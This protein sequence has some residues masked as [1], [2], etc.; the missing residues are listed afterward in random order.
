MPKHK[1]TKGVASKVRK[2][3]R[4]PGGKENRQR[5]RRATGGKR[6]AARTGA[7]VAVVVAVVAVVGTIMAKPPGVMGRGST[8][9]TRED[10]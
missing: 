5:H 8:A 4:V 10:W 2:A 7:V 3:H 9:V 6:K 1:G